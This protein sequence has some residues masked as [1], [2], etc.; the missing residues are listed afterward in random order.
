VVTVSGGY[1][2]VALRA[3]CARVAA[4]APGG[5]GRKGRNDAL[6]RAAFKLGQ[7]AHAGVLDHGQVVAELLD[8]ATAAGLEPARSLRTIGKAMAAAAAKPPAAPGRRVLL[9]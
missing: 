6:N 4:T 8:A 7:L 5:K 2:P 9:R 3:E 1:G